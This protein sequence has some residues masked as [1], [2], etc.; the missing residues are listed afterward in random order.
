MTEPLTY[1]LPPQIKPP[2][3]DAVGSAVFGD[4]SLRLIFTA[5]RL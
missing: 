2:P 4:A 5:P 3:A 1:V